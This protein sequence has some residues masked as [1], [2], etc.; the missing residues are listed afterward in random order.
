MDV[1]IQEPDI[2]K[3]IAT[4]YLQTKTLSK[5]LQIY[6]QNQSINSKKSNNN[7]LNNLNPHS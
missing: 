4:L 1:A 3:Q 7:S 5:I 6:L 2:S